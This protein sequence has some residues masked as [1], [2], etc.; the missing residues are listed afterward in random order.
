[1][2]A[3]TVAV[4]GACGTDYFNGPTGPT[5]IEKDT[6]SSLL[7]INVAGMTKTSDGVYYTD[8]VTG[9]G[10]VVARGDSIRILY[11]GYL[12]NGA[13]FDTNRGIAGDT[14]NL[15]FRLG[16]ANIITGFTSGIVG[17]KVGGRRIFIIPSALAYGANPPS[18]SGIPRYA[19]LVFDVDLI[20]KY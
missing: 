18:N 19:N 15:R 7:G 20:A 2:L 4:V 1:M 5:D 6:F 11:T 3:A 16:A 12:N 13:T 9:Q 17:M 10:A 8:K 14:T